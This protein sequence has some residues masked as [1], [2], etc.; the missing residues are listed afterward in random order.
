LKETKAMSSLSDYRDREHW[1]YS[2]IN[3]FLNICSLQWA[4]QRL[5]KVPKAFTSVSL[6]FGSAFHR[7]MEWAGMIRMEGGSPKPDDGAA[8]FDDLWARQLEETPD[9]R[10]DEET[11]AESCGKQGRDMIACA[12]REWPADERV[13]GVNRAFAVPLVDRHGVALERPLVGELDCV[14]EREQA[15]VI[16]DWK[17]SARRWP[18]GQAT[19]SLQP[20]AYLYART[21]L[22]ESAGVFRFDV[23]VKNKTP[24]SERHE[25]TRTQDQFDR[26]VELVKMA[27]SMIRAEHFLPNEQSFYCGGCPF[28]KACKAW[29]RQATRVVSVAA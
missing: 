4:F 23:T 7:A 6:V 28:Q 27:E 13:L 16:V 15:Q 12:I 2:S 19:K 25:T 1:S 11:D 20:T 22:G 21:Q 5:Y 26:M 17:T 18:K 29:H 24:V 9:V 14:V 8:L 3:Q 10:F